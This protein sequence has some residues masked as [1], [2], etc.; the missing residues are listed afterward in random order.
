[1]LRALFTAAS[2]LFSQQSQLDAVANNIANVNTTGF[3]KTRL[4]FQDLMYQTIKAPA[5]GSEVVGGAPN[6]LQIG[7][8]VQVA[9][10]QKIFSPGSLAQTENPLDL[11]IDGDG[12]FQVRAPDGSLMYSRDGSFQ[13]DGQGRLV[14]SSGYLVEP[15][16]TIPP[17]TAEISIGQDGRVRATASG[18]GGAQEVGQILLSRF[19]NP[20]GLKALGDNLFAATDAAGS[21]LTGEPGADGAGRLR[22]GY[23]EGSNVKVVEEMVQLIMA[24]R[25]FEINSRSVKAADEMLSQTNNLSRG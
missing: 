9:G 14:T 16:I 19:I 8:G 10:S 21:P 15:A 13:V 25:A 2:G 5:G 1:M 12:L 4:N 24:Q 6:G 22:Q 11:A 17:N 20:S 3:K 23:L 7:T 18:G